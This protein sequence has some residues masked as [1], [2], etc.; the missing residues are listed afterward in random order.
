MTHWYLLENK[1]RFMYL[2][3]RVCRKRKICHLLAYLPKWP[4]WLGLGLPC[5]WR[6]PSTWLSSGAFPVASVGSRKESGEAGTGTHM[7]CQCS[8]CGL[9][10]NLSPHWYFITII[11]KLYAQEKDNS[12]ILTRHAENTNFLYDLLKLCEPFRQQ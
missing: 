12:S 11:P 5:G 4:Y 8:T 2:K 6:G 10:H 7:T 9:C 3:G 1:K